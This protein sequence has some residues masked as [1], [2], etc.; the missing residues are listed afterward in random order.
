MEHKHLL[1][2]WKTENSSNVT[3]I[4]DL[5]IGGYDASLQVGEMFIAIETAGRQNA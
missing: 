4:K 1:S 3:H 5:A 2:I